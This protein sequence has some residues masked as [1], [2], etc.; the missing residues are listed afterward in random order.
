[1]L[2]ACI[3]TFLLPFSTKYWHLI[4]FS[5]AYGLSDGIFITTSAYILLSCVDTKK[6]TAS[7]A[8]GNM[9]YSLSAAAGGPIAGKLLKTQKYGKRF[10]C[11]LS[12][13]DVELQIEMV[14]CTYYNLLAQQFFM[15]QKVKATS[16]FCNIKICCPN[17]TRDH[18]ITY[19]NNPPPPPSQM[20]C[21]MG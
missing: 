20:N 14:C 2:I 3:A 18:V 1:M 9:F 7:F 21:I 10:L 19:K 12:R 15:L 16:T 13:N 5:T 17:C 6:R 11:N 8:I 4:L